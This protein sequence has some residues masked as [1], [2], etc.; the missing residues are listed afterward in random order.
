MIIFTLRTSRCFRLATHIR[1]N[2]VKRKNIF[3]NFTHKS[4]S[5][6]SVNFFLPI[7]ILFLWYTITIIERKVYHRYLFHLRKNFWITRAKY[8]PQ[9]HPLRLKKIGLLLTL[10]DFVSYFSKYKKHVEAS[11]NLYALSA[12]LASNTPPTVLYSVIKY[13]IGRDQWRTVHLFFDSFSFR[14]C[15]A[16][17]HAFF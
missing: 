16:V 9:W 8:P 10:F 3:T 1:H 13:T 6:R 17:V 12:E 11:S 5:S 7:H 4:E 2:R 15:T 14:T